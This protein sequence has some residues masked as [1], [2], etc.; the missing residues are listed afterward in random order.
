MDEWRKWFLE[1]KTTPAEDFVKI[2]EMKT[3]D[4]EYYINLVDKAEAV[5]GRINSNFKR[6]STMCKMQSNSIPCSR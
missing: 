2:V 4:L 6:V 5:F 1:K 3:K